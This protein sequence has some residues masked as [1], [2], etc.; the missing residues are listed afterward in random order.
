MPKARPQPPTKPSKLEPHRAHNHN[1]GKST[2]QRLWASYGT[3]QPHQSQK[4][5]SSYS[6]SYRQSGTGGYRT[7]ARNS[8]ASADGVPGKRWRLDSPDK[9]NQWNQHPV[10][11]LNEH[12]WRH[13]L[14]Q[15]GTGRSG[16]ESQL[17]H[18]EILGLGD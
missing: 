5:E 16:P 18:S 10:I 6:D 9:S 8:S 1:Q 14:C 15:D 4:Q 11:L 13:R 17:P 7:R 3:W 12:P 2:S